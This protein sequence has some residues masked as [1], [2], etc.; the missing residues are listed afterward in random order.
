MED[1]FTTST[2]ILADTD[3]LIVN[4][5][6]RARLRF[7]AAFGCPCREVVAA[8][9]SKGR[10]HCSTNCMNELP[11]SAIRSRVVW[12]DGEQVRLTCA[13]DHEGLTIHIDAEYWENGPPL[14]ETEREALELVAAGKTPAQIAK[15]TSVTV[16]DVHQILGSA[17]LKLQAES[18]LQAVVRAILSGQIHLTAT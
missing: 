2:W 5:N 13:R 17:R 8:T 12:V 1:S 10:P 7:G 15:H 3:G 6:G 11:E 9:T 18:V 14:S 4:Q 16:A